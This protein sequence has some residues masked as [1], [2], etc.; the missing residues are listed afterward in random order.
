MQWRAIDGNVHCTVGDANAFVDWNT[1]GASNH[2][3]IASIHDEL[4]GALTWIIVVTLSCTV[5]P[6]VSVGVVDRS[7]SVMSVS[8]DWKYTE[9]AVMF[10]LLSSTGTACSVS[11]TKSISHRWLTMK[12]IILIIYLYILINI[13]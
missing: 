2:C 13:E 11:V 10:T 3:T 5:V 4:N 6:T 1:Y 9:A 7:G 8:V 12:I